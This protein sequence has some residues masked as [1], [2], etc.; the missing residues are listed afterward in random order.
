[1]PSRPPIALVIYAGALVPLS[2]GLGMFARVL[3]S[4]LAGQEL[5]WSHALWAFIAGTMI[6]LGAQLGLVGTWRWIER[7][8][9]PQSHDTLQLPAERRAAL[10]SRG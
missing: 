3:F 8:A 9:R 4:V 5:D 6:T 1:M 7:R 10:Q 2:T